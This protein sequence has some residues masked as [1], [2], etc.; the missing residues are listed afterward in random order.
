MYIYQDASGWHK[1]I[2]ESGV[3]VNGSTSLALDEDGYAHITY[4][5]PGLRYA[6]LDISGWQ[7]QTLHSDEIVGGSTSVV[8]DAY[9]SPHISYAADYGD[10]VDIE[11]TFQDSS[12]WHT[13]T[14]DT[15]WGGMTTSLALDKFGSPRMSY[16]CLGVRYAHYDAYGWH[17]NVV[18]SV[19]GVGKYNSLALDSYDHP[20]I[21]YSADRPYY[22]LKYAQAEMSFSQ[23]LPVMLN[24]GDISP[25]TGVKK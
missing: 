6:Y 24:F 25:T 16:E 4:D 9:G 3:V 19:G 23:Y 11:Y 12:G 1:Q 2:V 5:N 14:V 10:A 22:D 7:H 13:Q 17:K 21:G 15:E 20:H 18:D 8:I